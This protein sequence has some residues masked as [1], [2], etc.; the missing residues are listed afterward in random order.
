MNR[1]NQKQ[2]VEIYKQ[3][4]AN[5]LSGE[6]WYKNITLHIK[7]TLLYGS[8]AKGTNRE[9]S[10]IDILMILPLEIEE[11]FTKGE[12]FYN[13]QKYEINIVLRSIEKLRE[14]AK[15]QTDNFQKEVFKNSIVIYSTDDEVETLL[16][17]VDDICYDYTG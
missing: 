6:T 10:D 16:K 9:D 15:A 8:I 4:L 12:Y 11:K 3:F 5:V 7:A 1:L 17:R 2:A 14:I 13:Y